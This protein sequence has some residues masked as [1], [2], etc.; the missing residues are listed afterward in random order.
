MSKN[1][2]VFIQNDPNGDVLEKLWSPLKLSYTS[3]HR[4]TT[5]KNVTMFYRLHLTTNIN[6]KLQSNFRSHEIRIYD[7]DYIY[8]IIKNGKPEFFNAPADLEALINKV[9]G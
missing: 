4:T 6:L 5:P 1:K 7:T 3:C 8:V 2:R 9:I